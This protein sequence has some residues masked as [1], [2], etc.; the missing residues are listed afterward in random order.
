V[1]IRHDF[2]MT[3]KPV[4]TDSD[5]R[6]LYGEVVRPTHKRVLAIEQTDLAYIRIDHQTRLQF[7]DVEVA[8]GCPFNLTVDDVVYQLD[9][10]ARIDLGPLV[11]LYPAVLSAAYVSGRADLHLEF[12]GG[13]TIVVPQNADY[14]AWEVHDD[15]GWLL[16]CLPGSSGEMAEWT[17]P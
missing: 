11:A 6:K 8:I 12:D 4:I 10:E 3:D 13:A 1:N 7:G 2:H 14:E 5:G 9:P 15:Q 17:R 16:V